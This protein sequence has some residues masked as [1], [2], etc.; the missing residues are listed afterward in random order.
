MAALK[1]HE[2]DA[3]LRRGAKNVHCFL[4][5]GPDTG[6]VNERC[7]A[8]SRLAG[9]DAAVTKLEGDAIAA[10]PNV[11]MDEAYSIGLFGGTKV[12]WL[13]EGSK[14]FH[15]IIEPLLNEPPQ[16][17]TLIV[18]AG[19]LKPSAALRK[20]F[21]AS[22]N[23]IALPCYAD[24]ARDLARLIDEEL[25][26]AGMQIEPVAKQALVE[27]L[28]GDRLATR[29][30]LRKLA[31]YAHGQDT[32]T[33]EDVLAVSGD[34]SALALDGILDELGLGEADNVIT[35]TQ[36]HLAHGTHGSVLLNLALR[37]ML[38][39]QLLRNEVDQGRT[40]HEAIKSASPPIFF[41]R[42]PKIE[43]QLVMWPLPKIDAALEVLNDAVLKT[44]QMP[45]VTDALAE[46]ALMDVAMMAKERA[47]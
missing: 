38:T 4:V 27:N 29:Q 34:V 20:L 10:D 43:R 11:L 44:R 12:L 32:V 14:Q 30:E 17:V 23:A 3:W 36:R 7:S 18:E 40:T 24:D 42:Q 8:L 6:L 15:D 33:L 19:E 21:E 5:Y 26:A 25:Q 46:R 28:G 45:F 35:E 16:A 1:A 39:L 31:L 22:K 47:A 41:K 13:R 2:V 37:H 9:A